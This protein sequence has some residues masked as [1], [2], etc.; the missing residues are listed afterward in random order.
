MQYNCINNRADST[1]LMVGN[2]RNAVFKQRPTGL[3]YNERFDAICREQYPTDPIW[4]V[5]GG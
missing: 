5:C 1:P 4:A 2:P 3:L